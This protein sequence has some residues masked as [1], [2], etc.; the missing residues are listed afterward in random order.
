[1][2]PPTSPKPDSQDARQAV[3]QQQQN[4]APPPTVQACPLSQKAWV[5]VRLVD[6]EGNPVGS[7][8]YRIKDPDGNVKEGKLSKDGSVRL[9][10]LHAGT[11]LISF[12][13][14][15]QDNWEPV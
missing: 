3:G 8:Q 7:V 10:G 4:P 1:M 12:P 2:S 14:L 11:C 15:D 9:E 6:M 13:E 5:E